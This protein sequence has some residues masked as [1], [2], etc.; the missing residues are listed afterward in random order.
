MGLEYLILT[1]LESL[2]QVLYLHGYRKGSILQTFVGCEFL[3]GFL[4][5]PP[6]CPRKERPNKK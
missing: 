2:T 3:S 6:K 1:A 4:L 5:F